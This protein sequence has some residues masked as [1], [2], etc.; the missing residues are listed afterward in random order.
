MIGYFWE[1]KINFFSVFCLFD[2]H[3]A[4][5]REQSCL[6]WHWK[7]LGPVWA[8]NFGFF[9][10]KCKGHKM[11]GICK[12]GKTQSSKKQDVG[13]FRAVKC[14]VPL[15]PFFFVC[16]FV[17]LFKEQLTLLPQRNRF[18]Y[19]FKHLVLGDNMYLLKNLLNNLLSEN[20]K[21]LIDVILQLIQFYAVYETS[22]PSGK[23]AYIV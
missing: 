7:S 23:V 15:S 1:I 3:S 20:T 16:L 21:Y 4:E 2:L 5:T 9:K 18:W 12:Q 19:N 10:T 17:G 14:T 6:S 22:I 13:L 8:W 11:K